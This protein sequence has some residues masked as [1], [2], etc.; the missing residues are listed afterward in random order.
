MVNGKILMRDRR[1]QTIDEMEV[2]EKAKEYM[3]RQGKILTLFL[4]GIINLLVVCVGLT[5]IAGFLL[6]VLYGLSGYALLRGSGAELCSV[7]CF[8]CDRFCELL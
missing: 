8:R 1:L 7:S 2:M 3:E 6:Y 4:M 5:G